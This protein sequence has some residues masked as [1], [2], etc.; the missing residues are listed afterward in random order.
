MTTTLDVVRLP[1]DSATRELD[2][3]FR[4]SMLRACAPGT[5]PASWVAAGP[6]AFRGHPHDP[7]MRQ[8]IVMVDDGCALT[9]ETMRRLK[10]MDRLGRAFDETERA[11]FGLDLYDPVADG[12]R[13]S[14]ECRAARADRPRPIVRTVAS[15]RVRRDPEGDALLV[16]PH[17]VDGLDGWALDTLVGIGDGTVRV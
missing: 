5:S 14:I 9:D 16:E 4:L 7:V 10:A 11:A 8:L 15:L 17:P 3:L 2:A 6:W 13:V 12:V 1:L